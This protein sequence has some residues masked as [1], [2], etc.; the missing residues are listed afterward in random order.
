MIPLVTYELSQSQR[1]YSGMHPPMKPSA[2]FLWL[3]LAGC[4]SCA[5]AQSSR[6]PIANLP[7]ISDPDQYSVTRQNSDSRFVTS[8]ERVGKCKL[9]GAVLT[10]GMIRVPWQIYPRPIFMAFFVGRAVRPLTLR[11]P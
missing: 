11:C 1:I 9:I 5:S 3:F 2:F 10:P 8:I 6:N 4:G 7:A